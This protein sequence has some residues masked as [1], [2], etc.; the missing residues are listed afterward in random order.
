MTVWFCLEFHQDACNVALT[1]AWMPVCVAQV[2]LKLSSKSETQKLSFRAQ[3]DTLSFVAEIRALQEE[4]KLS[5]SMSQCFSIT[6]A[7]TRVHRA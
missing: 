7:T 6:T 5:R 3:E 2:H 4:K 1:D